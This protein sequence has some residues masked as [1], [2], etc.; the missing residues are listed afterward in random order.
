MNSASPICRV[1][2]YIYILDDIGLDIIYT[3]GPESNTYRVV[4]SN[5]RLSLDTHVKSRSRQSN[6]CV[7]YGTVQIMVLCLDVDTTAV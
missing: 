4:Q 1:L 6:S 2:Q 7:G 5:V 3:H